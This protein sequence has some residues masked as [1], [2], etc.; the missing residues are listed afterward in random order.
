MY[1]QA[2]TGGVLTLRANLADLTT[3]YISLPDTKQSTATTNGALVVAGGVGIAKDVFVGGN[4]SAVNMTISGNFTVNGSTTIVN[5]TTISVDDPVFTLGGDTA[6]GSDDNKDRGIEFRWHNGTSAKVGF[7]G[8]DDST[9]KFTFIPDA[10]NTSEVFSGTKGTLD[11]YLSA[12]DLTTGTIA[13]GIL[14]NS[15]LYIGTTQVLLNQGSGTLTSLAGLTSVSATTFT[16]A[17]S[18]NATTAT[19]LAT[20]RAINGVNFDG[21]AA[22]T[23]PVN[24]TDDTTTNATYYPSFAQATSGNSAHK[25]ASTK[26][27]FNPSTGLLTATAFSGTGTALTAL[28]AGNLTGTIPSGVLGNSTVYIGTTAVALN[29]TSAALVLTG[30]TSIDGNAAT[31]TVLQTGRAINGISFNGSAAITVPINLTQ[32]DASAVA[33]YPVFSLAATVPGNNDAKMSSKWFFEPSTGFMTFPHLILSDPGGTSSSLATT[34]ATG[35]LFNTTATT[36]NLGGAATVIQIG[37]AGASTVNVNGTT[38]ATSSTT[39]ALVVDGG[40]G[41]A[42]RIQGTHIALT[43]AQATHA[44]KISL[45]GT[46]TTNSAS[47]GVINAGVEMIGG[48]STTIIFGAQHNITLTPAAATISTHYNHLNYFTIN[49]GSS[50]GSMYGEFIRL[51]MSANA[52]GGTV[53]NYYGTLI[54]TPSINASATK[55]I[56]NY[57]GVHVQ[58]YVKVAG[59]GAATLVVGLGSNISSGTG[60][61]NLYSSGTASNYLEGSTGIG[62]SPALAKLDVEGT[63]AHKGLV[64]TTAAA[65]AMAIDQAYAF[66]M[67]ST[68]LTTAW[69]NTGIDAANELVTG[70]YMVHIQAGTNE[71]YTAMMPWTSGNGNATMNDDFTEIPLMKSGDGGTAT[72]IFARIYRTASAAPTLQLSA[73]ATLAAYAYVLN[74]RRIW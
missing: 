32:E 71:F 48:A 4:I 38:D 57:Y 33:H 30:I 55:T 31:A 11:A 5:S 37:L 70:V 74:F 61:W 7:F 16:G 53:T 73:S 47:V 10:T 64:M 52:L 25:V 2:G 9:G 67:A 20:A 14:G 45:G 60:R 15:S 12:S 35:N 51:D 62:K 28:T 42:G 56:T 13:T 59:Q 29:R 27:T 34:E 40:L 18:G 50:Y 49:N 43:T 19:T 21:S 54:A 3:G 24:V 68:A 72:N 36:I 69:V 23:V 66:T 1:A 22:I 58:D 8:F 65:G 41:V 26:L 46:V 6:P 39:G 44:T 63:V 17:L